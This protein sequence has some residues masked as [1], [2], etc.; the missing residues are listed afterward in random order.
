MIVEI[1]NFNLD[2]EQ[3]QQIGSLKEALE[4]SDIE[5]ARSLLMTIN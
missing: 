4:D 5:K 1:E 2:E 3:Q